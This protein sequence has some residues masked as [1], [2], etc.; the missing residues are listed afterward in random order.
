MSV[1]KTFTCRPKMILASAKNQQRLDIRP[2]QLATFDRVAASAHDVE[3]QRAFCGAKF[4]RNREED[5]FMNQF[6]LAV[7]AVAIETHVATFLQALI[8]E[9]EPAGATLSTEIHQEDHPGGSN[10][11]ARVWPGSENRACGLMSRRSGSS[12]QK[13]SSLRTTKRIGANSKQ[14][15]PRPRLRN[16]FHREFDLLVPNKGRNSTAKRYGIS[17]LV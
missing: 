12:V 10:W 16:R 7:S 8:G 1:T 13:L 9:T 17:H 11:R 15:L 3:Q 14:K 4:F 6:K 5:I 2:H